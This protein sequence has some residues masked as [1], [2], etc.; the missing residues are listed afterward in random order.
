MEIAKEI[1]RQ[2]GGNKFIAMTGAK[3]FLGSSGENFLSFKFQGNRDL[4]HC[5]IILESDDTYTMEF[6]KVRGHKCLKIKTFMLIY[7][8][9]LAEIFADQT[10]LC[11]SIG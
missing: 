2:L 5:K 1:L 6:Y 9:K 4:T 8:D 7:C 11:L 10:G 3:N